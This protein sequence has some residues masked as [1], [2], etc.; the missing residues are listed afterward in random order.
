MKKAFIYSVILLLSNALAE[1]QGTTG[2]VSGV[3]ID[4]RG[5]VIGGAR[6]VILQANRIAI[7]ETF[8]NSAGEFIVRDILTGNYTVSVEKDGLTQPGG[9]QP[10]QIEAGRIIRGSIVL[11]VAAIED[12]LIVSA[13]RTDS[14]LTETPARAHIATESDIIRARR[15]YA[16][17]L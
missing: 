17:D 7:Q 4:S 14:R 5:A 16:A 6:V 12:S 9:A 11:T 2:S 8:T 3:V 10:I 13:T 1:A 15:I